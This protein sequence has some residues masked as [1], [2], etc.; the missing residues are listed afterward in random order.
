M[1]RTALALLIALCLGVAVRPSSAGSIACLALAAV[2]VY[3]R[4]AEVQ[5]RRID[6]E[7]TDQDRL[8]AAENAVLAAETKHTEIEKAHIALRDEFDRVKLHIPRP[9]T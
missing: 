3:L 7:V 1:T 9:R 5:D 2:V 4:A 8:D 6:R